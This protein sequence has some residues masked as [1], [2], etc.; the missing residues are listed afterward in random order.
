MSVLFYFSY[1]IFFWFILHFFGATSYNPFY[2]L[3][4]A[5]FINFMTICLMIYYHNSAKI[6]LLFLV[7]NTAI[8]GFPIWHLWKTRQI[9]L[10]FQDLLFGCGLLFVYFLIL[11][12][13]NK[14]DIFSKEWAA[15]KRG[16]TI[17]AP[18]IHFMAPFF[19]IKSA[20]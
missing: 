4:T 8:K 19:H 5:L 15:I 13:Y 11:W 3:C 7:A 10:R 18:F 14:F 9:L 2:F 16:Q 6:I 17:D 12:R 20:Q 1:W